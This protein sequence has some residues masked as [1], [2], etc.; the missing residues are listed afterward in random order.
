MLPVPEIMVNAPFAA[1][2]VNGHCDGIHAT[3]LEAFDLLEKWAAN[4]AASRVEF[5]NELEGYWSHL[6]KGDRPHAQRCRPQRLDSGCVERHLR[7]RP[8]IFPDRGHPL[9]PHLDLE[10]PR[11]V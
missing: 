11:H 4:P 5:F 3:L 2:A 10:P 9:H 6:P 8:A 1:V 7:G